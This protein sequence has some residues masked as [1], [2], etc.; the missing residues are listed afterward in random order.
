MEMPAQRDTETAT[1]AALRDAGFSTDFEV[2]GA[3]LVWHHDGAEHRAAP[4]DLRMLADY[5]FEGSS[6]PGD[7]AIL[8]VIEHPGSG[9]LGILDAAFGPEAG[10]DD[11][12]L[13][14]RLPDARF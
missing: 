1:I 14:R 12:A 13:L 5:R 11:A 7:E 10:P 9:T 8:L 4:E 2:D 3:E 6:D